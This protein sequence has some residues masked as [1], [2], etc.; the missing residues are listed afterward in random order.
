MDRVYNFCKSEKRNIDE[1]ECAT[2][3]KRVKLDDTC[4]YPPLSLSDIPN[5]ATNQRNMGA[6]EKEF[7][8]SKPSKSVLLEL[9]EQMFCHRRHFVPREAQCVQ[10]ILDKYP[11]LSRPDVVSVH[12]P[13]KSFQ[14]SL[15]SSDT[16]LKFVMSLHFSD[17]SRDG[18][19]N[20]VS[21][22]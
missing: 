22:Q 20:S 8:K 19:N 17:Y 15:L 9:M 7:M 16:F 14:K 10:E 11:A 4:R 3:P 6:L 2:A 1:S 21:P 12:A 5:E 18:A 13:I